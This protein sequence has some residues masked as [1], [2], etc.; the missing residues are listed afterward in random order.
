[1]KFFNGM[2]RNDLKDLVYLLLAYGSLHTKPRLQVHSNIGQTRLF[3]E[4]NNRSLSIV[5]LINESVL[6]RYYKVK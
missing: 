1:M 5:C 2:F 6:T 4:D 3:A